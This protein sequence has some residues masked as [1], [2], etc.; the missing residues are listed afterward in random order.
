MDM[1][2]YQQET[3]KTAVYPKTE[4]PALYAALKIAGEAAEIAEHYG[5]I[6]RDDGGKLT[7]ERRKALRK[8]I[9]DVLWY[10]AQI[11]DGLGMNLDDLARENLVK[12]ESRQARG[13]L[14]G[15][16]DDR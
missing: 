2:F 3:R 13:T 10:V 1:E 4:I 15:D 11:S 14:Y 16:G 9:G 5:K 12:L 7:P 6:I 8:E